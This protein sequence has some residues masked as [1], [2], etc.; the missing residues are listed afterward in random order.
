MEGEQVTSCIKVR[1]SHR[2]TGEQQHQIYDCM[3][4]YQ[5][6]WTRTPGVW[7]IAHRAMVFNLEFGRRK[8]LEPAP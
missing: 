7:R 8:V 5:S 1:A 2:G 4:H 6:R 3:G